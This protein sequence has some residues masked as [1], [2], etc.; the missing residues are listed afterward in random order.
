MNIT[1]NTKKL[2]AGLLLPVFVLIFTACPLKAFAGENIPVIID[3]PITYIVSG[4]DRTAG[5]DSF[6]L[7]PDDPAAP[8]PADS[9]DGEKT[10]KISR[11]GTYSFGEIYYDRPEI[12]W[13]TITRDVTEKKGVVKDDSVYRAKVIAL[14]DGHGYVLVYLD[15]SDD[16]HE[17]VYKDRVAPETGDS[18]E[19]MLHLVILAS[20]VS[21][22]AVL[23]IVRE[24]TK[25]SL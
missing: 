18:N 3:I 13:Y 19:F 24:K 22:L 21:M 11:E 20:A 4:N 17:L 2:L 16:K 9:I 5:G 7:T 25:K 14:N 15:G 23:A 12:W 10:I 8:M 1:T 6:T